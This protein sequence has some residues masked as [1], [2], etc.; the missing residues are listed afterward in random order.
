ML[1][2]ITFFISI[3]STMVKFIL[4]FVPPQIS[5]MCISYHWHNHRGKEISISVDLNM[6]DP[7]WILIYRLRV[8]AQLY[9]YSC[10]NKCTVR[11]CLWD[12]FWILW[13]Y[14]HGNWPI[15]T[16]RHLA[17]ALEEKMEILSGSCSAGKWRMSPAIN[18]IA[19]LTDSL[20]P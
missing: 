3:H 10:L 2:L 13:I 4:C 15:F 9:L 11:L 7:G 17:T 1:L 12:R 19:T 20:A 18:H 5:V 14:S 16:V 8:C 6:C